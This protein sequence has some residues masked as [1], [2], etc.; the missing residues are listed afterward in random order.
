MTYGNQFIAV[1]RERLGAGPEVVSV[2]FDYESGEGRRHVEGEYERV[3]GQ[4][5]PELDVVLATLV[6]QSVERPEVKP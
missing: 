1:V 3:R 4:T 6:V 5:P 2:A